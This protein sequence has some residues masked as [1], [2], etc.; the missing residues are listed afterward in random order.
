MIHNP[1]HRACYQGC[2]L[3]NNSI[4]S[5]VS[6]IKSNFCF[7]FKIGIIEYFKYKDM[8]NSILF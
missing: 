5:G 1:H 7:I 3:F 8:I 6:S 2:H 4:E